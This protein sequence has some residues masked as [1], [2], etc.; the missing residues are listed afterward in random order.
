MIDI[1]FI[2]IGI[3][4]LIIIDILIVV[5]LDG[6]MDELFLIDIMIIKISIFREIKY[7]F[8]ILLYIVYG[9]I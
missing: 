8:R 1:L 9:C 6:I 4:L 3:N 2:L 7:G 5:I